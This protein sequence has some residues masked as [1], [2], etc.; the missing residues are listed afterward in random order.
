[1]K[2]GTFLQNSWSLAVDP[3]DMKR[4]ALRFRPDTWQRTF[5]FC[6]SVTGLSPLCLN[7]LCVSVW[8]QASRTEGNPPVVVHRL[9]VW[10]LLWWGRLPADRRLRLCGG[11][12]LPAGG[13]RGRSSCGW[14]VSVR[15][16]L[17]RTRAGKVRGQSS[18]SSAATGRLEPS[19]S[20]WT[21]CRDSAARWAQ[22]RVQK[23]S[24]RNDLTVQITVRLQPDAFLSVT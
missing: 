22:T 9:P 14:S 23:R 16:R 18:S 15:A 7:H 11:Q 24:L 19:A 5:L 2:S 21:I 20:S 3:I 6:L 1:M 8:V 17:L 12:Q 4:E 13:R 10:R